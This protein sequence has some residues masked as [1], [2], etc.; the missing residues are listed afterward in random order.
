MGKNTVFTLVEEDICV[1]LTQSIM[2][3]F[4]EGWWWG[5]D[6]QPDL[7]V[8]SPHQHLTTKC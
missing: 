2:L 7:T 8:L 4:T 3:L 1:N 6:V 5:E